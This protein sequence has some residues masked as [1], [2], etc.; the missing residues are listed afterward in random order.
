MFHLQL[1]KQGSLQKQLNFKFGH[2]MSIED[3]FM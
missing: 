1:S 2:D 3:S